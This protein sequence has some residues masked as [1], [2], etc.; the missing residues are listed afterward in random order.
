M[1]YMARPARIHTLCPTSIDW[2]D[3]SYR[4]TSS[5]ANY[6]YY[7]YLYQPYIMMP[8]EQE[9]SA[10]GYLEPSVIFLTQ[11]CKSLAFHV[12]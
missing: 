8:L 7:Y 11:V 3:P 9:I 1:I 5:Y 6:Y 4:G 2:C 10:N 12:Y